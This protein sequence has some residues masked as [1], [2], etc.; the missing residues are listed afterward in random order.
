MSCN[1][2]EVG[3]VINNSFTRNKYCLKSQMSK[4]LEQFTGDKYMTIYSYESTNV[5][6]NDCNFVAPLYLD[7]DIDDLEHNY[8]KLIRDLMIVIYRL[9]TE[10]H[11][12]DKDIELYF[13]GAKGFHIIIDHKVFGFQPSRVL[14]KHLKSIALYYKAS[15]FTKCIDT[16]I[17]DY[18]RLFRVP[19]TINTK[20][21]LY[22]VPVSLN[23]LTSMTYEELLEY[24]KEPR[25]MVKKP[26]QYNQKAH[27]AF[28]ELIEKL[29]ER[30]RRTVNTAVAREYV[31][32]KKLLPCVEYI[33]QNGADEGQ[34]NNTTVALASSL[35]QIG[36]SKEEVIEILDEWNRTKNE[37]P[38]SQREL[39]T[40]I[41]SA[42]INVRNKMYY[43]CSAFRE[44]GTCV[45]SCPI[46]K[47]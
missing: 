5:T 19:N 39:L 4:N 41:N 1:M 21:G 31:N 30:E 24:A 11:L 20:T 37:V 42:Y 7:F 29:A 45:K 10:L 38:I 2:I 17:Y 44:L 32:E 33:L 15:T 23:K 22:K 6:S 36:H 25:K 13:S 3:G 40:T 14:N 26:I 46:N 16:A 28:Y 34:R 18:R 12:Q 9:K 8:D 43:G 47:K 27:D 35:L